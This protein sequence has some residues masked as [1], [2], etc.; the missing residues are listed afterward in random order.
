MVGLTEEANIKNVNLA[1]PV[2]DGQ[3]IY[4]PFKSDVEE[5]I[6]NKEI[7]TEN[8]GENVLGDSKNEKESIGGI[9][10]INT[11]SKDKLKELPG[12]RKFY[13]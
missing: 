3:K 8:A 4:I 2:E 11:A 9:I 5:S 1:Y 12:I 13:S 6:D 7:M 10:N